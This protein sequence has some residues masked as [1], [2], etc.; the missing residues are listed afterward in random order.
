MNSSAISDSLVGVDASVRLLAVEEFFDQ[1]LNFRDARRTA[2]KNDLVDLTAL[3]TRVFHHGLYRL[4]SIL[5]EVTA[6]LFEEGAGEGL[7]KVDS[8]D[9]A[10][11]VDLD[12]RLRRQVSLRS[13]DL[14]LEF[15]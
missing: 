5:E 11:D 1:L 2:N 10:F 7:I 8:I 3:E 9:Q 4:Q 13:F 6:E 15:L 12:L 14:R